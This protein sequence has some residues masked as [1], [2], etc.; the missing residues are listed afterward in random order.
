MK[1]LFPKLESV[2]GNH[3][4]ASGFTVAWDRERRVCIARRFPAYFQFGI[5]DDVLSR[6]E[7][8]SFAANIADAGYVRTK[9]AEY[10]GA[11]RRT[12]GTKAAV[13]LD[14]L[15]ANINLIPA[16]SLAEAVM[17][18]F[19][20][21][22]QF[23]NPHDERGSGFASIPAIWRFWLVMKPL[24]ERLDEPAR[25]GALRSAFAGAGSLQGLRFGLMVFRTSLGRDADG[26][27]RFCRTAPR[28][29]R[30]L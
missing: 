30:S 2:W 18:L 26:Q 5:G 28:G 1:R 16:T 11:V 29:C 13:L 23:T 15:S 24:L 27:T 7:L 4:Y 10:A 12:G 8:E 6:D 20:A 9:L 3:G 21:A 14:E 25:A 17:N 22:D 19:S